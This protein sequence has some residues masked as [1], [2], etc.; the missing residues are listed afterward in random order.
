MRDI[1]GDLQERVNLC[2]EQMR[3]AMTHF[4]QKAQQVQDDMEH[5][6]G[7]LRSVFAIIEKLMDFE[8]SVAGEVVPMEGQPIPTLSD[9]IR[10]AGARS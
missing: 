9:R 5:R 1:R 6:V 4:E 10:A 3:A 2:E 7:E 8:N